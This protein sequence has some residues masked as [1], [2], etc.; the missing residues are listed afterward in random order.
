MLLAIII[1]IIISISMAL[2]Y[3]L[4]KMSP[5][6]VDFKK[7]VLHILIKTKA[8]HVLI[9][10][11]I[12]QFKKSYIYIIVLAPSARML[13]RFH[14]RRFPTFFTHSQVVTEIGKVAQSDGRLRGLLRHEHYF[15][16]RLA[17][18]ERPGEAVGRIR[19]VVL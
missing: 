2:F 16:E 3:F 18:N 6:L 5:N 17:K 10:G 19:I 14:I 9:K 12:N 13:F 8:L 15:R 7:K 4:S 1:I 11:E